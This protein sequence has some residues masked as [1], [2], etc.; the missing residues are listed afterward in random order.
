MLPNEKQFD[1]NNQI[2]INNY[3]QIYTQEK[4]IQTK[5]PIK[6]YSQIPT[7]INKTINQNYNQTALN[8]SFNKVA[9]NKT[10]S[11]Y[12]EVSETDERLLSIVRNYNPLLGNNI[13]QN[14]VDYGSLQ[15]TSNQNYNVGEYKKKVY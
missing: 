2:Q 5:N 7:N 1:Q 14:G 6:T 13:D 9:H 10:N 11:I 4:I 15:P 8:Q 12:S 3:N